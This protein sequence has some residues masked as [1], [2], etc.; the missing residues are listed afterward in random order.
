MI[1]DDLDQ[2]NSALML[3]VLADQA[4][5][6]P[7]PVPQNTADAAQDALFAAYRAAHQLGKAAPSG[8][9]ELARRSYQPA[10]R[11]GFDEFAAVWTECNQ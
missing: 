10:V 9:D 11:A 2:A 5:G 8:F 1:T 7:D 3:T 6:C 4:L